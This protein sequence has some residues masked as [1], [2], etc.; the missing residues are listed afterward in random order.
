MS[1][2]DDIGAINDKLAD[3]IIHVTPGDSG[4]A[5]TMKQVIDLHNQLDQLLTKLQLADLQQQS[6]ALAAVL[7]KQGPRLRALKE[8]ITGTANDIKLVQSVLSFAAQA[9][10]ATAQVVS[11]AAVI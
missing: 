11:V 4:Q 7:A 1:I 3:W 5:D 8:Q 2:I 10:A 6:V 9:V